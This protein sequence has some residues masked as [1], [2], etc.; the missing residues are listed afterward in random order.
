MMGKAKREK[1]GKEKA[2]L[3]L[4]KNDREKQERIKHQT[5]TRLNHD[6]NAR[7]RA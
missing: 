4:P 2:N 3:I 7:R 6:H 5:L 1:K